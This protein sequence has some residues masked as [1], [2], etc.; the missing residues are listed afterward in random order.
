MTDQG[1]ATPGQ[2][3]AEQLIRSVLSANEK[4][5]HEWYAFVNSGAA[6]VLPPDGVAQRLVDAIA[7]ALA[8]ANEQAQ[9]WKECAEAHDE[10]HLIINSLNEQVAYMRTQLAE[11]YEQLTAARAEA[12]EANHT[13]ET[14]Q[15]LWREACDQREAAQVEERER[16]A[17]IC[18]ELPI[19]HAEYIASLIRAAVPPQP[20]P[21]GE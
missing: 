20:T 1:A 7:A 11:A 17:K 5:W 21:G 15:N 9:R 18:E 8:A 19:P 16:C 6:D 3:Q 4:G 12:V 2:R 10:D 13:V 14:F